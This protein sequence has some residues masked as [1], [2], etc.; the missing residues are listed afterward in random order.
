MVYSVP[1][2]VWVEEV[3][4]VCNPVVFTEP[5]CVHGRQPRLFIGSDVTGQEAIDGTLTAVP[6]TVYRSTVTE[7][8]EWFPPRHG[9]S[10]PQ[11]SRVD[12]QVAQQS[13]LTGTGS[14]HLQKSSLSNKI[15]NKD[16]S[17]ALVGHLESY[18]FLLTL[19][20]NG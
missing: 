15:M 16:V 3:E 20:L 8:H 11:V 19:S 1:I 7:G 2:P 12:G 5:Q 9:Q 13:H 17:W 4:S 18:K 6:P 14:V 10:L